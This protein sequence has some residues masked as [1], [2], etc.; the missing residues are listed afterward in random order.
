MYIVVKVYCYANKRN[1]KLTVKNIAPVRSSVSEI[2][3]KFVGNGED[4]DIFMMM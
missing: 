1:E 2:N 4:L 3:D